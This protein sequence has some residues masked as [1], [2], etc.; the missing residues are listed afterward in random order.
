MYKFKFFLVAFILGGIQGNMFSSLINL[1]R[2]KGNIIAIG[3]S[4]SICA[5]FGLSMATM[6]IDNLR[7]G[8]A[9]NAKKKIG[10]MLVSLLI[11]SLLPGVDIFG[12][13][14]SLISGGLIGLA[15]NCTVL[16]FSD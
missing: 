1:L 16:D 10:F 15:F 14:G 11:T 12:H 7:R 9:E 13:L 4:T 8:D 6:Y 3:A 5:I 2:N